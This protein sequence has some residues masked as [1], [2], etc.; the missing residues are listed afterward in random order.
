MIYAYDKAATIPLVDVYDRQMM[1]AQVAAAKDMYEKG[2]EQMKEFKKDYGDILFSDPSSQEWYNNNF[3]VGEFLGELY[4]NGI[5]PLRSAEGR[6]LVSQYINSRKYGDLNR[7]RANDANKKLYD[8]SAAKLGTQYDEDYETWRLGYNPRT[9]RSVN[10]DGTINA[11][12]AQY[13]SPYTNLYDMTHPTLENIDPHLLTQQQAKD[14]LS[15]NGG[16]YSPY[17]DY[18]GITEDDM[19]KALTDYMPGLR[20]SSSYQYQRH[21]AEQDLIRQGKLPTQKDIDDKFVQNAISANSAMLSNLS[22]KI[23]AEGEYYWDNKLDAAKTARDISAQKQ[24]RA[25][26]PGFD[27]HGNAIKGY[28]GKGRSGSK[29]DSAPS[30]FYTALTSSRG[31]AQYITYEDPQYQWICPLGTSTKVEKN[32]RGDYE[33]YVPSQDAKHIYEASDDLYV[34]SRPVGTWYHFDADVFFKPVGQLRVKFEQKEDGSV[35]P[36]FF[37]RGTMA[38]SDGEEIRVAGKVK[39]FDMEVT[40]QD[41]SHG[42]KQSGEYSPND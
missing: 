42:K 12:D 37:I 26:T 41:Y 10:P 9:F 19:R 33:Y 24:L 11:F 16:E 22:R 4:K 17:Y 23:N 28:T 27:E 6:A 21:L 40:E 29:D 14:I 31:V 25:N 18:T 8:A 13:A 7:L 32:D 3:N 15:K 36:R 2:L 34:D 5:D 39:L 20:N 1:L 35:I 38:N 30:P